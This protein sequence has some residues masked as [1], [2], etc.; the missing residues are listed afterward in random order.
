MLGFRT[1]PSSMTRCANNSLNTVRSTSS[2]TSQH[3]FQR[4]FTIHNDLRFDNRDEAR[5]LAQRRIARQSMGIGLNAAPAR[6]PFADGNHCAPLGKARAH[7]KIFLKAIAQSVQ[8][9]CDLFTGMTGQFLGACVH[10]DAGNDT[11][12]NEDLDKG[13]PS[14]FCCRIVSS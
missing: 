9:F 14:L 5:F 12:L 10:L 6:K 1:I 11:R 3:C 7:L 2:V 4:M 13:V 8:A